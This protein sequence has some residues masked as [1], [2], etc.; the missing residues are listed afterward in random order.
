MRFGESFLVFRVR[1]R[2]PRGVVRVLGFS[3][4]SYIDW[5]HLEPLHRWVYEDRGDAV[6][7]VHHERILVVPTVHL[8][9]VRASAHFRHYFQHAP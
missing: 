5:S 6:P 1:H 7:I 9:R 8:I 3:P 2:T 4:A